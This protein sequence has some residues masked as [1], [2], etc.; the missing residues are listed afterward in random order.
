[1]GAVLQNLS[2]EIRDCLQ[3]AADC[4]RQAGLQRDPKLSQD[5]LDLEERWLKL[6]RSYEFVGRLDAFAKYAKPPPK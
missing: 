6:A 3:H 5:F 1:M 2:A 4:A